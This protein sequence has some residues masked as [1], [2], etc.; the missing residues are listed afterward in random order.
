M[1]RQGVIDQLVKGTTDDGWWYEMSV[2]YNTWVASE[3]TQVA[4]ALRPFGID[5]ASTRFPATYSPVWDLRPF[6]NPPPGQ[7]LEQ[8]FQGRWQE[9]GGPTTRN[10]R[11][12]RDL[13]DG[14]W[15]SL[16]TAA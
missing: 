7:P 6:F 4:L 8:R 5:I 15:H 3:N 16:I 13:W 10:Y 14:R 2:S 1:R 12:I 11:A 9:I